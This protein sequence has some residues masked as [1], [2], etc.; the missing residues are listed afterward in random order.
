MVTAPQKINMKTSP[1]ISLKAQ[2]KPFRGKKYLALAAALLLPAASALAQSF[3]SG[4]TS[5]FNVAGSWSGAYI[6]GTPNCANDSGSANVVLIKPGDPVWQHGDTIAGQG[7][8]TSGSYLQTGS[9]NNTGGGNWMRL[10]V[11]TGGTVGFYTLSNG[12]VNVGG[13]THIGENGT[14]TLEIDGGAFSSA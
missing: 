7:A 2:P 12:V 8:G 9:T 6:G 10:G 14:A 5:D 3:W 11:G 13:E 4:G 1:N